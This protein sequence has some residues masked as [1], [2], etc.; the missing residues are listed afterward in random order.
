M[1]SKGLIMENELK[2]RLKPTDTYERCGLILTDGMIVECENI[3]EEPEKGFEIPPE[4][5]VEY[6]SRLIG[7][8]HTHPGE[9]SNLSERDYLGFLMWPK[10]THYII[11]TDG[12]SSYT[13]ENG[14]VLN[15]D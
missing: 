13:V 12:V 10:L 3:A 4:D 7:T 11:G 15:V 2:K 8:W 14:I 5:L 1:G 9:G 6:E